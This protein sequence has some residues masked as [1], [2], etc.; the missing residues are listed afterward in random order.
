[1]RSGLPVL[2]TQAKAACA[3]VMV[4]TLV[5]SIKMSQVPW[6][7]VRNLSILVLGVPGSIVAM[8][9]RLFLVKKRI[10]AVW[11]WERSHFRRSRVAS[12]ICP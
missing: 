1:M 9:K 3:S 12:N 11:C 8:S 5:L 4:V 6:R 7:F 10:T 2:E